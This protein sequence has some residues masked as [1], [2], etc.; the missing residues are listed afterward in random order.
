MSAYNLPVL[1]KVVFG[2]VGAGIT[3][4]VV[5]VIDVLRGLRQFPPPGPGHVETIQWDPVSVSRPWLWVLLVAAFLVGLLIGHWTSHRPSGS[6]LM[7]R[8]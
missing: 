5:A 7:T 8:D 1:R 2:F 4:F 6:R 3:F